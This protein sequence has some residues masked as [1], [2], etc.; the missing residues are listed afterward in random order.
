MVWDDLKPLVIPAILTIENPGGRILSNNSID[1]GMQNIKPAKHPPEVE[2]CNGQCTVFP[3]WS[4]VIKRYLKV[5]WSCLCCNSDLHDLFSMRIDPPPSWVD[6]FFSA[7][8]SGGCMGWWESSPH[9]P[10]TGWIK[11]QQPLHHQL[12]VNCWFGILG[13][14]KPES[15]PFHKGILG[16]TKPPNDPRPPTSRIVGKN[17][18]TSTWYF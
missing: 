11:M 17:F 12:M 10:P 15:N 2:D 4:E 9:P 1:W 14:P 8:K 13:A 18:S 3:E 6:F 5:F 7:A 16:S